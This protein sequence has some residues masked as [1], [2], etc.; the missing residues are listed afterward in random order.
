MFGEWWDIIKSIPSLDKK[1]LIKARG[2]YGT[3]Q[4]H[5]GPMEPGRGTRGLRNPAEA[6]GAYGTRQRD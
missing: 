4:R 6:R 1:Y 5:A 3:R 2:A